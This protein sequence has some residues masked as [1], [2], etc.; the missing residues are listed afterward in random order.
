MA[1][2]REPFVENGKMIYSQDF[3]RVLDSPELL[4]ASL[5]ASELKG[6]DVKEYVRAECKMAEELWTDSTPL[7][8]VMI[9]IFSQATP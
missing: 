3:E 5:A 6:P 9:S 8:P 7:S 4:Q 1:S 2:L